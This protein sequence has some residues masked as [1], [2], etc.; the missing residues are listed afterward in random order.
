MIKLLSYIDVC[1]IGVRVLMMLSCQG[2]RGT[3]PSPGEELLMWLNTG[4]NR[5]ISQ[6]VYRIISLSQNTWETKFRGHKSF[7]GTTD[8]LF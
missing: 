1:M 8:T 4:E 3:V 6:Y 5:Q 2:F 7:F